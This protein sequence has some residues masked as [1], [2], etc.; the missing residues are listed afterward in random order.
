MARSERILEQNHNWWH[1]GWLCEAKI[2]KK[3]I[4][5]VTV[6]AT[7]CS[8]ASTRPSHLQILS[9]WSVSVFEVPGSAP[10]LFKRR[11]GQSILM[12]HMNMDRKRQVQS[13][14]SFLPLVWLKGSSE[15]RDRVD[16]VRALR[17]TL[18]SLQSGHGRST[19]FWTLSTL[20]LLPSRYFCHAQCTGTEQMF[21]MVSEG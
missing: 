17:R 13:E 14:F 21:S 5:P 1:S 10:S 7:L 11:L 6:G 3:R 18:S 15:K 2:R 12:L 9:V 4:C 19:N 16:S 8:N 20:F